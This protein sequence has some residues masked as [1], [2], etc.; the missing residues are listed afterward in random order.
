MTQKI[1]G[2][3]RHYFHSI[4]LVDLYQT[5][6]LPGIALVNWAIL[7]IFTIIQVKLLKQSF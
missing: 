3:L 4:L 5:R 1:Y 7:N 6:E 2:R